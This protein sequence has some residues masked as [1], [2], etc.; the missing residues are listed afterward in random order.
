MIFAIGQEMGL[1][2]NALIDEFMTK[3]AGCQVVC[4][5]DSGCAKLLGCHFERREKSPR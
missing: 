2:S 1:L 3:S 5:G 4:R